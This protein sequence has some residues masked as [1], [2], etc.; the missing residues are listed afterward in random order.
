MKKL[1]LSLGL[2]FAATF[3]LT[4][5]AKNDEPTDAP[6]LNGPKYELFATPADTRTTNDGLSTKWAEKDSIN[7]FHAAAGTANYKDDADFDIADIATGRF[8]GTLSETLTEGAQYDW[9]LLYPY[10]KYVTT[11]ANDSAGYDTIG[12][13][14]KTGF[15]QTQNG[16]DSKAHLAGEDCPLY[17]K[18]TNVTY[19]DPVTATM[20]YLASAIAVNVTNNDEEAITVTGIS[21]TAPERIVG[22]FYTNFAGDEVKYTPSDKGTGKYTSATVNLTIENGSAINKGESAKFYML[23]KPFTAASGS[24]LSLTIKTDKGNCTK[25]LPMTAD[26]KFTA[27]KIKTLN[28]GFEAA[29]AEDYSGT[30]I[31]LAPITNG[32][33]W[34]LS[35]EVDGNRLKAIDSTVSTIT[36]ET[37]IADFANVDEK[38]VW[39]I[40]KSGANYKIKSQSIT[41]DAKY[42]GGAATGKTNNLKLVSESS[43]EIVKIEKDA[44]NNYTIATT[45]LTTTKYIARNSTKNSEFWAFYA[46]QSN[47]LKLIPYVVTPTIIAKDIAGVPA[48]GVENA[49]ATITL[50]GLG[51]ATVNAV[52]DGTVVTAASVSGN[53]LTYTVSANETSAAREGAITL[54]AE[55]AADVTIKVAQL[56][57]E[58]VTLTLSTDAVELEATGTES[59]GEITFTVTD[60]ATITIAAHGDEAGTTSCSWLDADKSGT[61]GILYMAGAN[62]GA[63]RVAYIVVTATKDGVTKKATIKVTQKAAAGALK[64]CTLTITA[65]DFNSTSYSANNG[66][67]KK[68][69]SEGNEITYYTYQ[70]MLQSSNIQ[71]QKSKAYLYNKT[72]L[73]ELVSLTITDGSGTMTVYEGT[74]QQPNTTAVTGTSGVYTFSAGQKYF[75]IK[76]GTKDT[77]K[78]QSITIVYKK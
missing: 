62:T 17:A 51:D 9:Y 49:T 25:E 37:T 66:D 14:N 52:A 3:A 35:S 67:H 55:G 61:N 24:T 57:K 19:P 1:I 31:I 63:E 41:D 59:D 78:C 34:Y 32:N 71:L 38:Y 8:T 12:C 73:G 65:S 47:S 23:I 16:N 42:L 22:T 27:G 26:V 2:M 58:T 69:D 10:S 36:D 30:Y 44:D 20:N 74:T 18:V 46:S 39:I 70:I 29:P 13:D 33:Y 53:T 54:S 75:Q 48:A 43:A 4:N 68:T 50:K 64:E 60:G 76:A 7:V 45:S 11:P 5:C 72:D 28:I 15:T 77:P 56:A 21:F 40:E 6:V